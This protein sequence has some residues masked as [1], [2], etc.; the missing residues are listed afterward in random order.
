MLLQAHDAQVAERDVFEK[1]TAKYSG[2]PG[3]GD[4]GPGV[5]RRLLRMG[6]LPGRK[7]T[8]NCSESEVERRAVDADI[9]TDEKLVPLVSH[10]NAE[11]CRCV[12]SAAAC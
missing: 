10:C 11:T 12:S 4:C 3:T 7:P 8:A 1:F 5:N 6:R 2:L 9:F